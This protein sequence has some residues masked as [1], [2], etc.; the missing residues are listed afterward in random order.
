[1]HAQACGC[2]CHPCELLLALCLPPC[3]LP[4][5]THSHRNV[6]KR[7]ALLSYKEGNRDGSGYEK[8]MGVRYKDYKWLGS[9]PDKLYKFTNG[10]F[11]SI[12]TPG[13]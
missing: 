5:H 9:S 12:V 3:P 10:E 8:C 2:I 6:D 13:L 4:P 7:Q 1:M 11:K